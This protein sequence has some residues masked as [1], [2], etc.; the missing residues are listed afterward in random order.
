MNYLDRLEKEYKDICDKKG[1]LSHFLEFGNLD[2]L[3]EAEKG[4]LRVQYSIMDAYLNVLQ[5][6]LKLRKKTL[7]DSNV[8][9][10]KTVAELYAEYRN[11]MRDF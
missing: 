1:A 6:R 3:N 10:C 5:E 4:L 8:G 2:N 7:R 11:G 9:E